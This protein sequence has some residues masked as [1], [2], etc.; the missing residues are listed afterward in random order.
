MP[1]E[2]HV[3]VATKFITTDSNVPNSR[4]DVFY[5]REKQTLQFM[6][7]LNHDH[8]IRAIATCAKGTTRCFIF[9]WAQGG[10]LAD[11]WK[12]DRNRLDK[13]LVRWAIDQMAGI[14]SGIMELHKKNT[15]HGD[16]KPQNILHFL[17]RTLDKRGV[18]ILKVADVGLAKVHPE[19]TK[20]RDSTTTRQSTERYEPPEMMSYIR[21]EAPIPRRYDSWSLGCVF[22]EFLVSLVHGHV[23]L[24]KFHEDLKPSHQERFYEV[25]GN[26]NVRHHIVNKLIGEMEKKLLPN[27]ALGKILELISKNLLVP[28]D[29]RMHTETLHIE[30]TKII[31]KCNNRSSYYFGSGLA[32]LAE[33]RPVPG[34]VSDNT[35]PPPDDVS[36]LIVKISPC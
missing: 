30:F 14:S 27:T 6:R 5:E 9:P 10:N 34:G 26:T 8:L 23:G 12:N 22:L 21:K 7:D 36:S 20:Y 24:V 17:D 2:D 3:E 16:V 15:R 1:N 13:H 29:K 33:V 28:A 18:G 4:V 25:E 31:R 19:Y 11:F 32:K 35:R